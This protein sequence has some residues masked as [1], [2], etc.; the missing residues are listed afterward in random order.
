MDSPGALV[1]L[2]FLAVPVLVVA[3]QIW[4]WRRCERQIRLW[5]DRNGYAVL[6]LGRWRALGGPLS[7]A[8]NWRVTVQDDEGGWR[9][10]TVCFGYWLIDV[11]WGRMVVEWD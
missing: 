9:T 8:K 1:L 11:P 7:L 4:F 2:T 6:R 10:G 5:A 3:Y